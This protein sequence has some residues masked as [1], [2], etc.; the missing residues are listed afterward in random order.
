MD[1]P[2]KVSLWQWQGDSSIVDIPCHVYGVSTD[3]LLPPSDYVYLGRNQRRLRDFDMR[4]PL[5]VYPYL[6]TLAPVA[7]TQIDGGLNP[8]GRDF[9][10]SE[11]GESLFIR[12]VSI[13][14]GVCTIGL[15]AVMTNPLGDTVSEIGLPNQPT[16]VLPPKPVPI[17]TLNW[18]WLPIASQPFIRGFDASTGLPTSLAIEFKAK[19]LF[20]DSVLNPVTDI[21]NEGSLAAVDSRTILVANGYK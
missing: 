6:Q 15:S 1:W 7:I 20:T 17:P 3:R 21:R 4:C 9:N 8:F 13:E 10:A 12:N 16:I 11:E 18:Y 5:W 19:I 14:G 2:H